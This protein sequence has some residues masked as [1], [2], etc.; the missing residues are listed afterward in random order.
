MRIFFGFT[1]NTWG[2]LK[3]TYSTASKRIQFLYQCLKSLL[4]KVSNYKYKNADQDDTSDTKC[5]YLYI[6]ILY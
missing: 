4:Y 6:C 3:Y 1:V 5:V 2:I